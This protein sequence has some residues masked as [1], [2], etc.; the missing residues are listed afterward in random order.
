MKEIHARTADIRER[1]ERRQAL[2]LSPFPS[3]EELQTDRV[4]AAETREQQVD[5]W[6][7]RV[8]AD[9]WDDNRDS[10]RWG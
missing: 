4:A 10:M 1:S 5:P 9:I 2:G 3:V 8:E 7:Q 6:P